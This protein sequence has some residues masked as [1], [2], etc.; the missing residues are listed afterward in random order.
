MTNDKKLFPTA[1][2]WLFCLLAAVGLW[3]Q[4]VPAVLAAG[5]EPPELIPVGHTV[6]VRLRVDGIVVTELSA[7]DTAEGT[8]NPSAQAGLLP[9]DM[10]THIGETAITD[11]ASLRAALDKTGGAAVSLRAQRNGEPVTLTLTPAKSS[12]DGGY[13][14]GALIRD[15]MAGIGTMTFYDPATGLFGALG[16]GICDSQNRLPLSDG[17]TIYG[18]TVNEI[19]RGTIGKPGELHGEFASRQHIGTLL[20]NTEQGIFGTLNDDSL[21]GS[22]TPIPVAPVREVNTGQATILANV[23]GSQVE[24]FAVEIMKIYSK[25]APN[26]RHFMLRVTDPRLLSLTGG[27]VQGMSGSPVLQNG[28]LVGAVTHVLVGDPKRGYGLF[29]ENMLET[30]RDCLPSKDCTSADLPSYA[31]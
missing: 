21:L 23:Q 31:A 22:Q 24:S 17:G 5:S 19:T 15:N 27:I 13:K 26:H 10:I 8:R 29:A 4:S 3:I 6:G 12:S 18:S 1:A 28:K 25:S 2:K 7:V 11:V 16:H 9:G 14:L 20:S 30:G